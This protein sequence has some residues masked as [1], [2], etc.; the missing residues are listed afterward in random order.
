MNKSIVQKVALACLLA[1]A[2]LAAAG[3]RT[4]YVFP[5]VDVATEKISPAY[6]LKIENRLTTDLAVLPS[7]E[8]RGADR[9]VL[10]PGDATD[11][12]LVVKNIKVGGNPANQVVDGPYVEVES[13]GFGAVL[14]RTSVEEACPF[15]QPCDLR[16][17]VRDPN[18]FAEPAPR[19]DN[20]PPSIKVC[21]DKCVPGRVVFRKG[22][23]SDEC[24][25]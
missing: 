11:L 3:C 23:E 6:R 22:P 16:V 13:A 19:R 15:C 7:E 24:A 4:Y 12:V 20:D 17:D 8:V 10:K 18:W 14:L 5:P 9:I 21:V 25:G 1:A 2:M